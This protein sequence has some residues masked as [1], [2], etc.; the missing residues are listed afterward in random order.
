MPR[1]TETQS[2]AGGSSAGR[3]KRLPA[4]RG[5]ENREGHTGTD[6]GDFGEKQVESLTHALELG[7]TDYILKP[8]DRALLASKLARYLK[9]EQLEENAAKFLKLPQ[10]SANARLLLD[11]EITEIDELGIRFDSKA[12]IPKGTVFKMESEFL[13]RCEEPSCRWS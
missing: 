1:K 12:L 2:S 3:G 7:A 4:H 8:L 6:C 10:G 13:N 5:A 11:G 9:T